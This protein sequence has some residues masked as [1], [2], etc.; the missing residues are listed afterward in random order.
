MSIEVIS[1]EHFSAPT[2]TEAAA[3]PKSLK[4]YAV[5]HSFLYDYIKK[6]AVTNTAHIKLM[7]ELLHC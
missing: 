3:T 6:D 2:H 1:M 5:L 4:C 7:I